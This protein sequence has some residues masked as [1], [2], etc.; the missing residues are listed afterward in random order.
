[1]C[2]ISGFTHQ[3]DRQG[4]KYILASMLEAI[5]YRGPD[6]TSGLVGNNYALGNVRLSIVDLIGGIQPAVSDDKKIAVVFNGEIFNYKLLREDLISQGIKFNSASEVE[7]LLHLYIKHG[8]DFI[9][10]LN[11]Q[12]AIAI[13]DQ[14]KDA[15]FLARDPFGIRP[16]FW[17][18]KN[19]QLGFASE[20]KALQ[21]YLQSGLEIDPESLLEVMQF[22]T[23]TGD[24][25]SFQGV[26][27][28]PP[29][30]YLTFQ[31]KKIAL[32]S[33]W[34]PPFANPSGTLKLA[35]E[36]EY[37]EAFQSEFSASVARQ[38][39]ADVEVGC[40]VS[41][42]I[43]SSAVACELTS[44]IGASNLKTFSIGFSDKEYDESDAQRRLIES[45]GLSNTSITLNDGDIAS[46]FEKV[47]WHAET[48]LFRTAP[49][50]L[51]LLAE[52]VNKSGIK[53]VMTG[54]GSDEMLLGYDIFREVKIRRFWAKNPESKWRGNLMKRLYQYLPQYKN[55]RYFNLLLDFYRS[56]LTSDSPHY[57]L[58]LRWANGRALYSNLSA[59]M[60]NRVESF[61]PVSELEKWLPS[62][63]GTINDIEKA[64]SIE[65]MTLL[66]NYL[67]SSQGDRMSLAHSV[68]GRY[69]YLDLEFVKFAFTLPQNIKL[70]GLKDKYVLRQSF[71]NRL[72]DAVVNRPKIAYQAPEMKAFFAGG[73]LVDFAK[74]LLSPDRIRHN[75]LFDPAS[76]ERLIHVG[77]RANNSRL[78]FRDN[79]GFIVALSTSILQE[80]FQKM[81]VIHV[82]SSTLQCIK[83]Q[84]EV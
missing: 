26:K 47:V 40:Y 30:H 29:G 59:D 24:K 53:V 69:P 37:F 20:I 63:Y 50:P 62:S 52:Q 23:V 9:K 16:L 74:D 82:S 2:G 72:P 25:S 77:E 36:A 70:K 15:L 38:R 55:H 33:Y 17:G 60:Q 65:L 10:L 19:G 57:A 34:T 1:M 22:W 71:G 43:D 84:G 3:G 31:D 5:Q 80:Q 4:S 39:M 83:I 21:Q 51:Y 32:Q 58:A 75:N 44:Q 11:G 7:T 76:I 27:Q 41:G 48:P 67:L 42:G 81:M 61:N 66:P 14:R 68:E 79:M 78:S 56:T 35:N 8:F 54:E 45:L 64:Q 49:A 73:R 12:F 18:M 46:V 6:S 28:I 13:F